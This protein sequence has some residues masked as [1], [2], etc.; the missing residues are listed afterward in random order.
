MF[1]S[2]TNHSSQYQVV[3]GYRDVLFSGSNQECWAYNDR[4]KL[5]ESPY[6]ILSIVAPGET[7]DGDMHEYSADEVSAIMSNMEKW[8][9]EGE[10]I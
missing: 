5:G 3:G 6:G 9:K 2:Y 1:M 7:V 8:Y 4:F 10:H